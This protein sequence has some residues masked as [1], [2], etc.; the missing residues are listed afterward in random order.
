MSPRSTLALLIAPL[1]AAGLVT[2]RAAQQ[3]AS[4]AGPLRFEIS[5]PAARSD[6]PFALTTAD[7][8]AIR[9]EIDRLA[10]A[11]AAVPERGRLE[12]ELT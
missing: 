6:Q 10:V 1:A 4:Q 2:V 7:I 3:P 11:W 5:Y 8:V 12:L 9:A